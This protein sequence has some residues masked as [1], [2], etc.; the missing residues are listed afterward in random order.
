MTID[1]TGPLV[2]AKAVQSVPLPPVI[3]IVGADVNPLP[4]LFIK[5]LVTFPFVMIAVADAPDP[6]P[7]EIDTSGAVS[8]PV[9]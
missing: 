4:L 6:P 1:W 5:I 8:Y 2:L 7:P 9:P 3:T